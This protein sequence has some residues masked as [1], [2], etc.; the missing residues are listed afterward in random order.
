VCKAKTVV[1]ILL[2]FFL[3]SISNAAEVIYVDVNGPNDPGTG[4][5][6]DPFRKIQYAINS[7]IDGD[8]IEIRPG[9]YTADPNN[10]N[11]D[12][13]GKPISIRSSDPCNPDIVANTIIDPNQAGRGFYIH[14]GE[15][16]YCVISGLTIRNGYF[17]GKGGGIY[18]YNSSPTIMNCV[19]S[20]NSA[21][22]HGGAMFCQNSSPWL[23]GCTIKGNSAGWDGGAL[24]CWEGMP[25]FV[26]CIIADNTAGGN[27]GGIDSYSNGDVILTN[28]TLAKNYANSG[29][30]IYCWASNMVVNNS[31]IR[32]SEAD[33]GSQVVLRS[34]SISIN[35]SDIENGWP[36][37][38]G[39][40]DTDPCFASFDPN[41]EPNTWDFHL[42]S[43]YGRLEPNSQS[44]VTD[45][46]TSSC[47]DAG[48]PNSDWSDEPWPNG[49][50]LNMGAYG[51]TNQASM[52]GNPADFNIDGAADFADFAE[53]SNNWSTEQ[54]CI[55]DIVTDGIVDFA[56]LRKFVENWLWQRE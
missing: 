50:R 5:F 33:D 14:S 8:T 25:E 36:E 43:A 29:G 6:D 27:G 15:D 40:I 48:D 19:I 11:L 51:G 3:V 17:G 28:C 34:G 41:G 46:N 2:G 53:F 44:W 49:K 24:E 12:P 47:I 21:G 54:S 16:A 26:N 56:D 42:Q 39:N 31:I 22:L 30:A 35:H 38:V 20:G 37:G 23:I 10:Y 55:Y 52:N 9:I 7:A 13:N 32:A 1:I 4:M 18:I 45:S